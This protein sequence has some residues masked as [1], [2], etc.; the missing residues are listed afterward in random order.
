MSSRIT[1]NMLSSNYLRNMKRNLTN[2]KTLQ[3]QLASG[4]EIQKASDNPYTASR[5][6][7]LILKFLII[8]NIMK[9]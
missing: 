3:N 7:Q 5:S 1:S 8:H 9:I 6:M 4:K 2:M